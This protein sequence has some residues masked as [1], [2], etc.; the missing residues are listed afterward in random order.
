MYQIDDEHLMVGEENDVCILNII[1][2]KKEYLID[3]FIKRIKAF[4]KIREEV[5]LL[6]CEHEMIHVYDIKTKEFFLQ[7]WKRQ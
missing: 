4:T 2:W 1:S 3:F 7:L 5:I 6:G